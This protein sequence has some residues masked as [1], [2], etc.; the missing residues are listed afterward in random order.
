MVRDSDLTNQV[1]IRF[2]ASDEGQGSVVEAAV[3]DIEILMTGVSDA[4]DAIS[5][6]TA[7]LLFQNRPNPVAS[8]TVIRFGLE[9]PGPARL[10]VF[11]IQGRLVRSLMRGRKEAGFHTILWDGR[12]GQGHFAPSGV[13]FYKLEAEK[14]I[15]T[16]KLTLLK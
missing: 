8:S 16:R 13:Y 4:S 9:L 2:I 1:Q 12:D 11:D 7:L 6:A 5:S 14:K 15:V 3:D 10:A